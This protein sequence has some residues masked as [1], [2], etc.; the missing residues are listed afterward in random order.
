MLPTSYCESVVRQWWCDPKQG[1]G[2]TLLVPVLRDEGF[3]VKDEL[4]E[5][6]SG[7]TARQSQQVRFMLSRVA[8]I[9]LQNTPTSESRFLYTY[10]FLVKF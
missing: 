10:Y 5:G 9:K 2:V 1:G 6:T 8:V 4:V 3:T 7:S